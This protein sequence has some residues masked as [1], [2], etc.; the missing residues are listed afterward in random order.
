MPAA[1]AKTVKLPV[2]L[3]LA[4]HKLLLVLPAVTVS[5]CTAVAMAEDCPIYPT[6]AVKVS[7]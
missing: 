3:M 4:E 7:A 5:D 1:A 2:L 6:D